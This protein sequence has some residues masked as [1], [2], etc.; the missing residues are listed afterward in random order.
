MP[1]H[2]SCAVY[3][4]AALGR[5]MGDKAVPLGLFGFIHPKGVDAAGW[6][7]RLRRSA[8]NIE[9]EDMCAIQR[10]LSMKRVV[11]MLALMP[12]VAAAAS[13]KTV[14]SDYEYV[15]SVDAD[16]IERSGDFVQ[17]WVQQHF[18]KER[19]SGEYVYNILNGL[20][21]FDCKNKKVS[22]L[23]VDVYMDG[24]AVESRKSGKSAGNR[25]IIPGT[26]EY[27]AYRYLCTSKKE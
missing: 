8:A 11:L 3:G 15:V 22:L 7:V 25:L 19:H 13:W 12:C 16:S 5:P 4:V 23:Q 10:E 24:K 21:S 1:L 27:F 26:V 20:N 9:M 14:F 2:N 18:A 17:A 6:S